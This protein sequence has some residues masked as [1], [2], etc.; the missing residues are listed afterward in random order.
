MSGERT[1]I[2]PIIE[3]LVAHYRFVLGAPLV[4]AILTSA[5]VL[6]MEPTYSSTASFVPE[7]G[8][9]SRLPA[10]LAGVASQFGL[11]L[12]TEASR[13]PAFYA[14][15]LRSREVLGAVLDAKIPGP[16]G[17]ADSLSVSQLYRVKGSTPARHVEEGVKALRKR[18]AVAVDQRTNVVRLSVEGPSATAARDVALLLLDRLADFNLN[19]RQSTA[20]ER[21]AFVEGRVAATEGEL[22]A[23]EEGLRAFYERNRQWQSSPG[24]QFEEQRLRRQVTV[25]QELYL[26]LRREYEMARVEEVNNTPVLTLIDHPSVPGMR[27]RPRRTITV[28]LVTMVIGIL[29]SVIAI[30]LQ[31]HQE[32]VA[33][34]DPE[35][36]RLLQRFGAFR[37]RS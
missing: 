30:L 15:L 5:A 2:F 22:R 4:A 18:I 20:R 28:L 17:D 11:N 36:M 29:A 21:R 33:S 14:D 27:I 35:Y 25:Q 23:A 3:T 7:N 10:G 9:T 6:V 31:N 32:L 16:R 37:G 24:L 12:G 1:T 8:T 34:A 19:T 26:T 13:S